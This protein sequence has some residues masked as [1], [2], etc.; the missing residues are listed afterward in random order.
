M[1]A[2]CNCKKLFCKDAFDLPTT[3]FEPRNVWDISGKLPTLVQFRERREMVAKGVYV[4]ARHKFKLTMLK[5]THKLAHLNWCW[6]CFKVEVTSAS[7]VRQYAPVLH[8]TE[9]YETM[10]DTFHLPD[11]ITSIFFKCLTDIFKVDEALL[12]NKTEKADTMR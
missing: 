3:C 1:A 5:S 10:L 11:I 9:L 6:V 2:D 12:L 8:K 7:D 4:L